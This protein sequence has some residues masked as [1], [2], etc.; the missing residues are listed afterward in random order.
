MKTFAK[1]AVVAALLA[2][3]GLAAATTLTSVTGSADCDGYTLSA[4][5]HWGSAPDATLSYE[6]VLTEDGGGVVATFDATHVIAN[7]GVGS[8][9]NLG[10][11][12]LWGMELCG[13]YTATVT[14]TLVAPL[15]TGGGYETSTG[16]FAETFVC[17]CPPDE[18]DTC[19]YTP[20]FW[21]NHAAAWPVTEL[22]LGG[23]TYDQAELLAIL[24]TPVGGDATIILAYHLI[25]AKLNVL[26][27]SDPAINDAIMEADDLLATYPL[28]SN[29]KGDAREAILMV[30]DLLGDYNELGCDEEEDEDEEEDMDKAAPE[31]SGSTWSQLKANYR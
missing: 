25:A 30:K 12:G 5:I 26:N 13:T 23:M 18:P 6:A 16:S 28:F 4:T 2:L 8:Y 20:G 27:G 22:S 9:Q 19:N 31:E 29:P 7:P 3:P 14:V 11:D 1:F 24:A 15:G 10:Y 21:K 17:D